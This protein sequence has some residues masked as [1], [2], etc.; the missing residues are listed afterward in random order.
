MN[1]SSTDRSGEICDEFAARYPFFHH[2]IIPHNGVHRPSFP[3]NF[4]MDMAKG[5][6]VMF[7]DSDDFWIPGAMSTYIDF[8]DNN[9]EYDLYIGNYRY[10]L[11]GDENAFYVFTHQVNFDEMTFGPLLFCCVFRKEILDGFRFRNTPSEDVTFTGEI[12][13]SGFKFKYEKSHPAIY[14]INS[15]RKD[16]N[17]VSYHDKTLAS[18]NNYCWIVPIVKILSK[19]PNCKYMVDCNNNVV[20]K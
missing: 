3:R 11:N 15:K 6:H 18:N 5:E 4:G 7:L 1:E 9:T 19:Y 13:L 8:L 12:L 14:K 20:H 10:I 2:Y 16:T 17:K